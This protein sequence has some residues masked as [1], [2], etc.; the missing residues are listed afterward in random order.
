MSVYKPCDIRGDAA[1]ELSPSLYRSWGTALGLRLEPGATFV[2]GGD[3]RRS[4]P[5][6]LEALIDGLCDAGMDVV[7]LGIVPTPIVYF[8]RRHFAALGSAVITASHSPPSVNG[9]KWITGPRPGSR[10]IL[11]PGNGCWSVRAQEYL[12]HTFP[13]L[14]LSCIHDR[15][16]GTFPGRG[17]DCAP[18]RCLQDLADAVRS[19]GADLGLAF[20]GDGDRVAFV[21][22]NGDAVSA[23]ECAWIL[24][25]SFGTILSGRAFVHDLRF[26]DRVPE[27]ARQLGA[28]PVP[29]RSGYAFIRTSMIDARAIFGAEISGHYFYGDLDGGDDGLYTAC[30][31]V[32]HLG[33]G[34]ARIAELRRECPDIFI[35]PD[36]RL[37]VEGSRQE[38]ILSHVRE[39]YREYPLTTLDG[40]RVDFPEGWAL[41]R[42]S[43]TEAKLTFRFEA[44]GEGELNRLVRQYCDRLPELGPRLYE[45]YSV[46]GGERK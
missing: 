16:D 43:V 6:F 42:R 15:P 9:L 39:V 41:V 40:V 32:S 11:D 8:A 28:L 35:T 13:G 1:A 18:T 33:T 7:D 25:H 23:E 29:Q 20:D 45:L 30:R 10:I 37:E 22:H 3:V 24:L 4:T 19:G 27:A 38:Q 26:S 46:E 17:P 31:M 36:L 2:A 12:L 5:S 34:S 44:R 14:E 21:D